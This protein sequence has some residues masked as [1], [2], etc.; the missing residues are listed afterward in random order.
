[1][2][3][4]R[5]LKE[6]YNTFLTKAVPKEDLKTS[7]AYNLYKTPI[8]DKGNQVP[9]MYGIE[10]NS[11]YQADLCYMPN[12]DGYKYFLVVVDVATGKTEA[13][14]L[15]ERTANSV[16]KA[17]EKIFKRKILKP[18]KYILQTDQGTEFRGELKTYIQ[19][20]GITLRYAKVG[21]SRQQAFAEARNKTIA[22]AL[23][24]RMSA[25]ELET[26]EE[27][28]DWVEFLPDLIKEL[29]KHVE[30][31]EQPE[32][33]LPNITKNNNCAISWSKCQSTT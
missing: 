31:T 26:G 6:F 1:M 29:N 12:D 15:K 25:N 16:K 33:A 14:P 23:F 8:K 18:P 9:H 3:K 27:D 10:P 19:S 4:K 5:T 2:P 20:K 11:V 28:N 13:E 22:K 32:K 7:Q 17:F 21:R 24:M 30:P